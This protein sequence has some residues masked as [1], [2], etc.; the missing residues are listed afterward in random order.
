MFNSTGDENVINLR[1]GDIA[2][3][4]KH[5]Y[6]FITGKIDLSINRKGVGRAGE[7]PYLL[8][9]CDEREAYDREELFSGKHTTNEE[10]KSLYQYTN[11]MFVD[12]HLFPA[13]NNR[14]SNFYQNTSN[15][16]NTISRFGPWLWATIYRPK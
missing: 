9:L 2:H 3:E 14:I 16:T 6:Q 13:S 11:L 7:G 10:L 1:L 5:G 8:D 12:K 15:R 4:F